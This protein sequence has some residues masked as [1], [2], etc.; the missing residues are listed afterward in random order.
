MSFLSNILESKTKKSWQAF[1]DEV[2]GDFVEGKSWNSGKVIVKYRNTT[3]ELDI[4]ETV[5]QHSKTYTRITCRYVTPK[6]FAF[7]FNIKPE[8]TLSYVGKLFGFK[9]IE[10]GEETFDTL[11]NLKSNQKDLFLKFLDSNLLKTML[12]DAF[13]GP[14]KHK[15]A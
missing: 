4:F 5:G 7:L 9:D 11:I 8:N 1:A 12:L 10:V 3:I 13:E 6:R 2:G 14:P 15:Q